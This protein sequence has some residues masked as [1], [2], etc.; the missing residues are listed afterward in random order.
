VRSWAKASE[1]KVSGFKMFVFH[2]SR[3][4]PE[5]RPEAHG[6]LVAILER[7]TVTVTVKFVRHRA[8][9][10]C[11]RILLHVQPT[12]LRLRSVHRN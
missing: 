12:P 2:I 11:S 7:N 10:R 4:G 8:P 6:L 3:S 9:S 1:E 5:A